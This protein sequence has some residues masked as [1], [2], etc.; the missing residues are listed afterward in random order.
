MSNKLPD[1]DQQKG[2]SKPGTR[3]T[4]KGFRDRFLKAIR[5][6]SPPP[7]SRVKSIPRSSHRKVLQGQ[8]DK[9]AEDAQ[10]ASSSASAAPAEAELINVQDRQRMTVDS[11]KDKDMWARAEE[12]LRRDAQKREKMEKYDRILEDYF[13]SK[14]KPIGTLERREQFLGFLSLE[15]EKLNRADS[16][17]LP[18]NKAKRFFRSAVESII[19]SKGIITAAT[20]PCLPAS[21]ACAGVVVL[22]SFCVQAADQRHVL[23][24]GLNAISGSIRRLAEYEALLSKD[25][26]QQV[27]EVQILITVACRNIIEFQTRAVC[28][29]QLNPVESKIRNMF[30]WDRWDELLLAI[31]DAEAKIQGCAERK[32]LNVICNIFNKLDE[33]KTELRGTIDEGFSKVAATQEAIARKKSASTFLRLLYNKACPYE[34]SKNR[35]RERVTGTCDWFTDHDLFKGWN[36]PTENIHKTSGVLY[37]TADPG[38]GKSVLS[39]HDGRGEKFV[40]SFPE[41]WNTFVDAASCRETVCVIDALDECRDSDRRE[42]I[43]AITGTQV[44]NL[45]FL[46][47]SRPYEHIRREVCRKRNTQIPLIHLQ[48]DRG[49]TADA[50]VQEIR[51]VVESRVDETADLFNLEPDERELM[52]TQLESVPNRTYLWITLVFD[53][54]MDS[55]RGLDK[56]DIM[57]LTRKLPQSANDAYEKILMKSLDPGEARRLLHV[58]LAAKRP[59]SLTEMSIAMA[60]KGVDCE[61]QRTS[62][63]GRIIPE[64][65]MRG[66]L[67]DIC[68]LFVAVVDNKVYLLHQTAREFLIRDTTKDT[69]EEWEALELSGDARTEDGPG[70][71]LWKH[72][73]DPADCNSVLAETCI[74]YL[75][76]ELVKKNASMLE[77]SATYWADHY[78]QSKEGYQEA[79]KGLTRNLCLPSETR[80]TWTELHNKH[81]PNNITI[82][83]TGSPLCLV[84]ALGLEKTVKMF[85]DDQDSASGHL[86]NGIDSKDR[87][88]G[89]TP[90]M[91]AA[92]SGF[93]A[94]VKL[95]LEKEANLEVKDYNSRTPLSN[96]AY[97]GHETVVKLLL[98]KGADLEVQDKI[99]RTPLSWAACD[100]NEVVVKLLLEKGADLEVKDDIGRTP[101]SNAAF[102]GNETVVKL[103][104]EKGAN[105][106]VKDDSEERPALLIEKTKLQESIMAF[107]FPD[108]YGQ[109][110]TPT[111]HHQAEGPTLPENNRRSPFVVVVTGAGKGLGVYISLAYA[112][113]GAT[114]ICISSRTQSDLDALEK[115]LKEVNPKLE[116]LS[117]IC[118][119]AKPEAVKALADQVRGRWNGRLDVAIANAGVISQYLY[120]TDPRTGEKTNRRL[121]RGIIEDDDFQRV[122]DINVLGSYY[123][124]KY[125][126]PLLVA[127]ENPSTVRGY[128]VLT[129]LACQLTESSFVPTAYNV[130]KLAN[131][132]MVEHMATDH[133]AEGLLAFA[134]HPGAVL[135]PQTENHSTQKGDAWD[136]RL[137]EDIGLCGGWLTWLTRERREWL[138][139]R[140]LAVTWDVDE[141]EAMK[142]DIV[143]EDKLKFK[144]AV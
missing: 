97:Y 82:P 54:L 113:A 100:G 135:T 73:I 101:L 9:H 123:V 104:L 63:E 93:V 88:K 7:A 85:L 127:P 30:K 83:M 105:L 23:L 17:I 2:I 144:M 31:K 96:A 29:L 78:R 32:S 62:A 111:L 119:T 42:L 40:E 70:S 3:Q 66:H 74:Q 45:K 130:A 13:A 72:S 69:A 115:R 28:F 102:Y 8:G 94:V 122:I 65:R 120:D 138:S 109:R 49:P 64:S 10:I 141:L 51:L 91:W 61:R 12:E 11:Y 59:L 136:T 112:R 142:D 128:V 98:E 43:D 140:Y 106:E 33:V 15:I 21:V 116:V 52:K 95:L 34:G 133:R 131:V 125:F 27:E 48:G 57:D 22:L 4:K 46:V 134:V 114:G 129:S 137:T 36:S 37:V 26:N 38:C 14:L 41:L 86:Q 55:K 79:A 1:S 50:I 25:D 44:P 53:G 139:G 81:H 117:V 71:Y 107:E 132:R 58:I 99:G 103:L 118:D 87:E 77:Y 20:A 92:A 143:R 67:R 47:T 6:D 124:A 89:R 110:F 76:S 90:L 108:H 68:G 19:A 39:R 16:E 126:T 24:D 5:P 56:S 18:T 60:F 35:N 84:S 75:L 80:T 121:P